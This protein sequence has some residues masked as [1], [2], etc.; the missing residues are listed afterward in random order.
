MKAPH[1]DALACEGTRFSSCIT[2]NPVC[3]PPRASILTGLL[4]ETPGVSDNGIDLPDATGYA[5]AWPDGPITFVVGFAPNGSS[6]ISA[7][8]V[9][10]A[11]S[12]E[13]GV[14]VLVENRPGAQGRIAADLVAHSRPDGRTFLIAAAESLFRYAYN[15]KHEIKAGRPLTPVTILASQPLIMVAHPRRG[16]KTLAD[17]VAAAKSS[18]HVLAYATPSAGIGSNVIVAELIFR[19]A[20]APMMTVPYRGGGQAVQ[21]MLA[22][23]VPLGVLGAAPVAPYARNGKLTPLAVTSKQRDP[24]LP[25]VPGMAESG[26][27][28]ID[29]TQWF[30][31][32]APAETPKEIVD[33]MGAALVE[34]LARPRVVEALAKA[35]LS[36][37]GGT[38]EDAI[39]RF[40]REGAAWLDAVRVLDLKPD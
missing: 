40:E 5:R 25:G 37:V 33:R 20:G 7:R 8:L 38:P 14:Q 24:L 16:W 26:Y 39:R 12:E 17:A 6:D 3:Q 13:L 22:G 29:I 9:G 15:A 35:A 32:F 31:V 18:R 23:V 27:P 30:A 19:K 28:D 1:L 21:D 10:E 4:P 11:L 36:P 2:P 34:A